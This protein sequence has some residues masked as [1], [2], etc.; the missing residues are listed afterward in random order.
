MANAPVVTIHKVEGVEIRDFENSS[1]L[2]IVYIWETYKST[3]TWCFLG[4]ANR[5]M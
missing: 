3:S 5:L 2:W 4:N 1:N